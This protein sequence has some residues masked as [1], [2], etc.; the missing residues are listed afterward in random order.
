ML[1][2]WTSVSVVFNSIAAI[3][4]NQTYRFKIVRRH[5]GD[6]VTGIYSYLETNPLCFPLENVNT[7]Q[8][9]TKEQF[10]ES[11]VNRYISLYAF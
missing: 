8:I 2:V 5:M 1:L 3:S 11:S 4:N 6:M 9:M 10:V 7:Q